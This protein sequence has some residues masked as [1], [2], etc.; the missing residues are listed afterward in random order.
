[1]ADLTKTQLGLRDQVRDRIRAGECVVGLDPGSTDCGWA[2]LDRDGP[3]WRL[4]EAGVASAPKGW[5][6]PLRIQ[7]IGRSLRVLATR[8]A[9]ALVG[10]EQ[11]F[12]NPRVS[13][14][15]AIVVGMAHGLAQGAFVD[16]WPEPIA[17]ARAKARAGLTGAA[18][19][20][21]VARRLWSVHGLEVGGL[22]L[23][24]TDAIAVALAAGVEVGV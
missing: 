4:I 17:P 5:P 24:A 3:R 8:F 10:I 15:A 19:K 13:A 11:P 23:D 7:R 1:M 14:R 16:A 22:A 18:T 12:V 20:E 6:T 21:D 2:V 9:P